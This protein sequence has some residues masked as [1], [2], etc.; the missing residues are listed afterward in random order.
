MSSYIGQML[1]N[2]VVKMGFQVFN[3]NYFS[4]VSTL[5]IILAFSLVYLV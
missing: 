3:N 1:Y 5:I 2:N 4:G